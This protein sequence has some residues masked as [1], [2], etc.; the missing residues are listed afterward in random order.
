MFIT[1][2]FPIDINRLIKQ[3][4]T[5]SCSGMT[6]E[7]YEQIS[8]KYD[9]GYRT[10]FCD[11]VIT[12]MSPSQSHER[13]KDFI[14]LLVVA[15]CDVIDVIELDYYPTGSTAFKNR[16]RQVG[17]E[18]DCSFC[19]NSLKDVPDLAIEVVFSSGGT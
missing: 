13:I 1:D 3:D 6:W 9:R 18:P 15:Y 19:F 17:K 8:S 10:S 11:G 5:L 16:D 14:F 4:Q 12:I 7:D 2:S